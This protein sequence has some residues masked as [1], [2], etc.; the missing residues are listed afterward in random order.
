MKFEQFS[1]I[2]QQKTLRAMNFTYSKIVPV[3]TLPSKS[4]AYQVN[5]GT[6]NPITCLCKQ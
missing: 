5:T 2:K 6:D 3:F 4:V 1:T